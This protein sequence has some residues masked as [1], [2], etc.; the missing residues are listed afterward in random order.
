MAHRRSVRSTFSGCAAT[1]AEDCKARALRALTG[2][3]ALSGCAGSG[4]LRHAARRLRTAPAEGRM[5]PPKR[6]A[7]ASDVRDGTSRALAVR[8]QCAA[9]PPHRHTD[10]IAWLRRQRLSIPAGN[11]PVANRHNRAAP[12]AFAVS[13]R[14]K[15]PPSTLRPHPAA[16]VAVPRK[17]PTVD[18][19]RRTAC[20][21]GPSPENRENIPSP[22][23]ALQVKSVRHSAGWA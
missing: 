23:P 5:G 14:R 21:C 9:R 8:S 3:A 15:T 19:T 2:P 11:H 22:L 17:F 10:V 12:R 7:R 16:D 18:D 13:P 20:S 4:R 1:C 6:V